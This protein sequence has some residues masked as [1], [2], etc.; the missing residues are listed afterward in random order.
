[1]FRIAEWFLSQEF[2]GPK[3]LQGV[4]YAVTVKD[5]FIYA[6]FRVYNRVSDVH[7]SSLQLV[8]RS[9]GVFSEEPLKLVDKAQSSEYL[10]LKFGGRRR[11]EEFSEDDVVDF[12]DFEVEF[13]RYSL[14]LTKGV[15]R[16]SGE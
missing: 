15:L 12:R 16:K 13:S 4:K 1:M 8:R 14:C 10:F 6:R 3:D 2:L 11:I 5:G 7:F 9:G